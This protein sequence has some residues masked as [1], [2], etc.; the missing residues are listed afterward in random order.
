MKK[1]IAN[2]EKVVGELKQLVETM[3]KEEL[4]L[5]KA[6]ELYEKG[7]QL[8]QTCEKTLQD[9]EQKIKTLKE[10]NSELTNFEADTVQADSDEEGNDLPF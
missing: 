3:E 7:I 1:N 10:N 2:F 6:V 5:E 8:G 9:A 4:P